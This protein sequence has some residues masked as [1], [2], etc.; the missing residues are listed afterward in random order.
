MRFAAV[1]I[2]LVVVTDRV[3]RA[4]AHTRVAAR[5]ELEIDR[6]LLL[7]SDFEGAE[8]SAQLADAPGPDGVLALERQLAAR[9]GDEHAHLQL[10]REALRPV[11]RRL[12]GT[13]D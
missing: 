11:E 2:D 6:V 1:E 12:R 4:S 7:P 9:A 13:D 10:R 3:L 5:A 8:P